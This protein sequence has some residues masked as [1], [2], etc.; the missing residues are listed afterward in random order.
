MSFGKALAPLSIFFVFVSIIL[1]AAPA[2]WDENKIDPLVVSVANLILWALTA[3][4][5]WMHTAPLGK[6]SGFAVMKGI[7]LAFLLKFFVIG[8]TVVCYLV[9]TAKADRSFRA[10]AFAGVLYIVYSYLEV[11]IATEYNKKQ[12]A[13]K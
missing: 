12:N 1:L 5:L 13:N 8:V 10:L 7:T 9:F 11:R 2:F 6:P 3:F 4:G